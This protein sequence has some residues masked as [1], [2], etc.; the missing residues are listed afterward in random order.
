MK[1]N[2]ELLKVMLRRLGLAAD[3][4]ADGREAVNLAAQNR[5]A[6]IFTDLEMPEMDGFAAARLIREQE[7]AGQRTPIVAVSALTA[8]GT[9]EKCLAAGIDDYLMK[10]IYL[11]ALKSLVEALL[12]PPQ[13]TPPNAPKSPK[14][15]AYPSPFAA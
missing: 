3:L 14:P 6:I 15:A 11:P 13:G 5:Y 2:R 12:P 1:L 10:P 4:A 8:V 7:P 9:R